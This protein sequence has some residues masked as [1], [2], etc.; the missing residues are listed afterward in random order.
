MGQPTAKTKIVTTPVAWRRS[1]VSNKR[2]FSSLSYHTDTTMLTVDDE[3]DVENDR[4]SDNNNN[5]Y[6]RHG[7]RGSDISAVTIAEEEPEVP[8]GVNSSRRIEREHHQSLSSS[9]RFRHRNKRQRRCERR[10]YCK[11]PDQLIESC[12][13][14]AKSTSNNTKN[15]F[16]TIKAPFNTTFA[17]N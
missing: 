17:G 9:F 16:N 3:K 10:R 2:D 13:A 6:R 12:N 1:S 15:G 14:I 5:N 7:G 8:I 4:Y 11:T